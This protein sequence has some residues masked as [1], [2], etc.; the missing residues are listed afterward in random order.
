[1]L[2]IASR[3]AKSRPPRPSIPGPR[4]MPASRPITAGLPEA[5]SGLFNWGFLE[6]PVQ[7][8]GRAGVR[9]PVQMGVRQGLGLAQVRSRSGHAQGRRRAWADPERRDDGRLEPIPGP[10]RQADHLPGLGGPDRLA[11]SDRR[12][13][14]RALSDKFG[15]DRGDAEVRQALHGARRRALRPRRRP[16]RLQL[17][18]FRAPPPPS[19]D[20]GP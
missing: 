18:R 17:R 10:R 13:S 1:M 16:Q 5:S 12:A 20:R 9:W 8:A 3:P 4:T 11:L 7:R 19:T 14:T 2:P 6:A 15:G